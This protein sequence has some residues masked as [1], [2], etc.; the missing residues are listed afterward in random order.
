MELALSGGLKL[1]RR[2]MLKNNPPVFSVVPVCQFFSAWTQIQSNT[3][4]TH[5]GPPATSWRVVT[6]PCGPTLPSC[7]C[8][9]LEC[10]FKYALQPLLSDLAMELLIFKWALSF[11]Y[12][13]SLSGWTAG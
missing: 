8:A 1:E 11:L 13:V 5:I 7:N 4:G 12:E 6:P 9:V 3:K 2:A 10:G